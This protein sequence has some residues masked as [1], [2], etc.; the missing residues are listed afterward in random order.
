MELANERRGYRLVTSRLPGALPRL[1]R[2][3]LLGGVAT[4]LL[5]VGIA[6]VGVD[7]HGGVGNVVFGALLYGEVARSVALALAMTATGTAH[8]LCE[9]AAITSLLSFGA[10]VLPFRSG[11]AL[12]D[13][14]RM[15]MLLFNKQQAERYCSIV[16]LVGASK[17]G[18]RPRDW[19]ATW[20]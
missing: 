12:S 19:D 4:A 18:Q 13:G 2:L 8:R 10:N 16:A 1:P 20:I 9:L 17:R 11:G 6:V 7:A 3:L 5:A 14:A 15:K